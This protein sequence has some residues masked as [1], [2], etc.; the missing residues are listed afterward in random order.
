MGIGSIHEQGTR[1][2]LKGRVNEKWSLKFEKL[3]ELQ[4][5]LK[6]RNIFTTSWGK[7]GKENIQDLELF[8]PKKTL[9]YQEKKQQL[10]K[11]AQISKKKLHICYICLVSFS[12]TPA[13][14]KEHLVTKS[15]LEKLRDY[16]KRKFAKK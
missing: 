4:V 13:Q 12:Q 7:S 6:E 11:Q 10:E 2:T 15:H 8:C 3:T 1:Y 14:I 9:T 5:F 16:Q